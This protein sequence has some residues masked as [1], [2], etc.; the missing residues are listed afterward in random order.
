NT[1]S[2]CDKIEGRAF[3]RLFPDQNQAA[4][5][6]NLLNR[7]FADRKPRARKLVLN[8]GTSQIW[9]R[10][11][12]RSVRLGWRRYILMLYQDLTIEKEQ[13][14]LIKKHSEEL[15]IAHDQLEKRVEERTVDLKQTNALLLVEI[16]ER[17]R[18]E[19]A[20]R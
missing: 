1:I 4:E 5:V 12:L 15:R 16:S 3:D 20:L 11:H 7:T 18:T 14:N 9:G 8:K 6:H 17:K 10:M 2:G 19:Q 13:I